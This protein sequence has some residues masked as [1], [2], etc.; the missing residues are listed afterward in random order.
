VSA[1]AI[2]AVGAITPVGEDAAATVGSI[3]TDVQALEAS[4]AN[5]ADERPVGT[6]TPIPA[7]P[8]SDGL[9]TSAK[10]ARIEHTERM[11]AP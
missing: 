3:F 4:P 9:T 10:A 11:T 7:T 2:E 8:T 6:A 5:G 1:L